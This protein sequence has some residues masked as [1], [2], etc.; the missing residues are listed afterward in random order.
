MFAIIST[1]GK[2]YKVAAGDRLRVEKLPAGPKSKIIFDKV[3]LVSDGDS[4]KIGS[5]V[6]AGASVEAEVVTEGKGKKVTVIKYK[7]KVRY[8][9]TVG[10][11]QQFTEVKI[12]SISSK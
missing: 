1:G 9:K 8:K 2:Q 6:V 3:L 11:R 10:H 4:I 12:T 5:P 7:P